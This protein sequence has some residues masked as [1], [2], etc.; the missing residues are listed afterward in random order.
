MRKG[1]NFSVAFFSNFS[2][3][4]ASLLNTRVF[5]ILRLSV[6]SMLSVMV[7]FGNDVSVFESDA[8]MAVFESVASNCLRK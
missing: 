1:V 8:K 2:G 5:K 7:V 3:L 4:E 6:I